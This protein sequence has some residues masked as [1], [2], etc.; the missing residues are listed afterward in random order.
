MIHDSSFEPISFQF[1][2]SVLERRCSQTAT[3]ERSFAKQLFVRFFVQ[4]IYE[5]IYQ[6]KV[7]HV[8]QR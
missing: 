4:L 5:P 3:H 1:Y 6:I 7:N 8:L 2:I